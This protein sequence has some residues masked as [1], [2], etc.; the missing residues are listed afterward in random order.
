M[1]RFWGQAALKMRRRAISVPLK[2][3]MWGTGALAKKFFLVQKLKNSQKAVVTMSL[4]GPQ[5]ISTLFMVL[6]GCAAVGQVRL[7]S[8]LSFVCKDTY[9]MLF[10]YGLCFS[11]R[12]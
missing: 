1:L 11:P 10:F 6:T 9:K 2:S 7:F 5:S 3:G 12:P 4:V 8:A